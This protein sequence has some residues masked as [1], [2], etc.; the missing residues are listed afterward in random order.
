MAH[1]VKLM[2]DTPVGKPY[3]DLHQLLKDKQY[4]ILTTNVDMQLDKEFPTEQICHFQGDMRYRQC[5]QPCNDEDKCT[6]NRKHTV[7]QKM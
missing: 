7:P 2:H 4:F 3:K 6:R 5:Q 1:Y